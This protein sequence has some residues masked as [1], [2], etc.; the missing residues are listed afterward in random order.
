ML[1]RV[2]EYFTSHGTVLYIALLDGTK[3]FDLVHHI[4]L[5]EK[6]LVVVLPGGIGKVIFYWYTVKRH[7]QLL[8]EVVI[9]QV[10]CNCAPVLDRLVFSLLLFNVYVSSVILSLRSADLGCHINDK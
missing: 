5:F 7:L 9:I 3:A 2:I 6:L 10:L 1:T 4:K 8:N